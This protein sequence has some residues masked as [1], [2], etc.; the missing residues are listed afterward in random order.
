MKIQ[1]LIPVFNDWQSVSKLVDK[2]NNLSINPKF[3]ISVIIVN[4][5]STHDRLSQDK[6]L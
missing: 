1:I 5:A 2:I 3:Q 6:N 4:D